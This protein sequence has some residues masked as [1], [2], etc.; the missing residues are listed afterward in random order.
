MVRLT[1]LQPS[2]GVGKAANGGN[3]TKRARTDGADAEGGGAAASAEAQEEEQ[4]KEEEV[5]LAVRAQRAIEEL[6]A[7]AGWEEGVKA[8]CVLCVE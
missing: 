3:A 6:G 8:R 7:A 1:C 4:E 5:T 2:G